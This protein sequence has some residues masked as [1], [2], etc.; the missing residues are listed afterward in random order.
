[1]SAVSALRSA[2][3]AVAAVDPATLPAA[4]LEDAVVELRRLIDGAR[5]SAC[6]A[7]WSAYRR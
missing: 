4:A 3:V 7:S 1:M 2:A 5:H 6:M